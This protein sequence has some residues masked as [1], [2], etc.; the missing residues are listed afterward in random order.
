MIAPID[1]LYIIE[2]Y[3]SEVLGVSDDWIIDCKYFKVAIGFS[4]HQVLANSHDFW[5]P[6]LSLN[7]CDRYERVGEGRSHYKHMQL[8]S[9]AQVEMVV[10]YDACFATPFT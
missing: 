6:V 7:H 10:S 3:A 2:D 5:D 1:G 4:Q 9:P 8:F